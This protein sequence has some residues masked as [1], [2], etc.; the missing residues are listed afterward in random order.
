VLNQAVFLLFGLFAVIA[1][2]RVVAAR[3][4]FHALLWLIGC[5]LGVAVLLVLLESPFAAGTQLLVY[6]GGVGLLIVTSLV[7]TKGAVHEDSRTMKH[8]GSA[9]LIALLLFLLMAW[10]TLHLPLPDT[11]PAPL[12]EGTLVRLGFA[13]VDPA[14][15]LLPFQVMSLMLLVA[16]IGALYLG[17]ER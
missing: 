5:F 6:V 9:A 12:P 15:F 4:I 17:K 16:L 1:A 3:R 14:G 2:V 13:L 10:M 7:V 8:S 11:A